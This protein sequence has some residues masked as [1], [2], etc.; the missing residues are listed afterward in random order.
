MGKKP[1]LL[2][3]ALH[4][5]FCN[6]TTAIAATDYSALCD[7]S[8]LLE[9]L[10]IVNYRYTNFWCCN[11]GYQA[12]QEVF[13]DQ[14]L[15]GVQAALCRE[16]HCQ[17]EPEQE[18]LHTLELSIQEQLFKDVRPLGEGQDLDRHVKGSS[19][20]ALQLLSA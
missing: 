11:L 20:I 19:S 3:Y 2:P 1:R 4:F 14:L 12:L 13:P 17:G 16:I 18:L 6:H 8:Y 7:W 5:E 10:V 9:G 15:L